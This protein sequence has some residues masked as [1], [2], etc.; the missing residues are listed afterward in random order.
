M[1]TLRFRVNPRPYQVQTLMLIAV[2]VAPLWLAHGKFDWQHIGWLALVTAFAVPIARK[3]LG[4]GLDVVLDHEGLVDQRIG[5]HKLHWLNLK[6]I[7]LEQSIAHDIIALEL[8]DPEAWRAQLPWWQ[9][10]RSRVVQQ[11]GYGDQ[12]ISL[13]GLTDESQALFQSIHRHWR[14][15]HHHP[16]QSGAQ[17]DPYAEEDAFFE[18]LR[19]VL[20]EATA[21]QGLMAGNV[22]GWIAMVFSGVAPWM[23]TGESLLHWGGNYGPATQHGEPWRLLTAPLIHAGI[24]HLIMNMWALSDAGRLTERLYGT[25]RFLLIYIG[26][27]VSGGLASLFFTAQHT[28]SV[29]ASG[30]IFGVVG[31]LLAALLVQQGQ[32]PRHVLRGLTL[33]IGLFVVMS[34]SAASFIKNIDHAAHGGGLVGGFI[35]GLLLGA[36]HLAGQKQQAPG[37]VRL[38]LACALYGTALYAGWLS[39]PQPKFDQSQQQQS[40]QIIAAFYQADAQ[41]QQRFEQWQHRVNQTRALDPSQRAKLE[42]QLTAEFLQDLAPVWVHWARQLQGLSDQTRDLPSAA[43]WA[44]AETVALMRYQGVQMIVDGLNQNDALKIARGRERLSAS[45][46][47]L[48]AQ[49]WRP[50]AKTTP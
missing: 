32:V 50:P 21:T 11:L 46:D 49:A 4:Y 12:N 9:R 44:Q 16:S 41:T 42:Q 37:L 27:A 8:A 47:E 43:R 29:G 31:A 14:A 2:A 18:R 23:P 10:L 5:P 22:G 24:A 17:V 35:L 34:F 25:T 28:V 6:R 20:P 30:A 36:P 48:I 1:S 45:V 19:R 33:S 7:R 26:A 3:A 40:Q 15:A 39:L 38:L 13:T